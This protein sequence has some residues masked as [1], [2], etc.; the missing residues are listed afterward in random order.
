MNSE[1]MMTPDDLFVQLSKR[2]S[3]FI[4][5]FTGE[6]LKKEEVEYLLKCAHE[7]PTHKSTYPWF[8]IVLE[9]NSL[10]EWVN[11]AQN[12]VHQNKQLYEHSEKIIDKLRNFPDHVSHAIAIC[13][14]RDSQERV[15]ELEE[16]MATACAVQNIYIALT[17]LEETGGYW[18]TGKHFLGEDILSFLGLGSKDRCLGFFLLGK[19]KQKRTRSNRPSFESFVQW[20]S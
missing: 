15:P 13:M 2:R 8:F 11:I 3:H 4:K 5:E 6:K 16:I 7:A 20:K 1:H 10:L 18:S 14:R 12:S 17:A 9:G 19:V